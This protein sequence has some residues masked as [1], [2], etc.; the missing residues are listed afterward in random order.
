MKKWISTLALAAMSLQGFAQ[1]EVTLDA[2]QAKTQ[3]NRQIYGHF[4]EHLGACIYGGLY[5]GENNTK[6]PNING[7]RKDVIEALKKMKIPNLRWPGGCFADTYHWKDG[8]GPKKQRPSIVN[9]WW[10]GVTE[11]NSFGTHDFLNLCKELGTE[12]YL[13]GNVGSGTVKELSDWVQYVNHNGVSPMANLRKENGQDKA[14]G[15]KY[16]GVGNEAW[17]CG[18][19]MKAEYYANIYRQYATFMTDWD[20]G[21][22]LFRIASGANSKDYN[23]TE[24]LMRDIPHH[25]LEGIALHHYSVINWDK[26]GPAANF[27]E[28]H[29][30]KTMQQALFMDELIQKHTAIMDKYDPKKKVALVVDEWGGWYEVEQG[31]NPGFLYQQNTMRDAVL[32]GATL[33]IF[34]KHSERV[35]MANLA[36]I[37]N[38]LQAVVLTKEEKMILTP[39]YHVMEMYNV[40]QDATNIPVEIKSNDYVFGTE[41]LPAVSVSASKDQAG[42]VH[43]SLTNIDINKGQEISINLKGITAKAVTG[44]VLTSAKVQD[45]NTF[46]NPEKVKPTTFTGASISGG[47]LK[48]KLPAT[49]V[50]VL[51]LK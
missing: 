20:N 16:W 43:I 11:D 33:N 30:F 22:K 28:E 32:A 34:H 38:V 27:T 39:T 5:V 9:A 21:S 4:A 50:V 24:V 29:Y 45:H 17:G 12:P 7:A 14:W 25:M 37:V 13:A 51:E 15:V 41:K 1:N 35:R 49:S 19:N 26:K 36:Q 2:S 47:T 48:V 8:I 6:I 44:R 23:W 18:G 10:G 40:H 46:D 42:V 31:T 3:I